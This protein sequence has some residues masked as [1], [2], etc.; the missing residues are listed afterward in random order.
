MLKYSICIT[1]RNEIRTIRQ[2]LDSIL[3]QI[4]DRFEVIVVD[5]YSDDGSLG[6]LSEYSKLGRLKLIVKECNRGTGRQIAFENS[7][8]KYVLANMDLDDTFKP[9]LTRL[10]DTYHAKFEGFLLYVNK[11]PNWGGVT[12][13]P[14]DLISQIGGW[15]DLQ[16][17]EDWDLWARAGKIGRF[18]TVEYEI[19]ESI[20]GH[21][22][23]KVLKKFRQ[24]FIKYR[25]IHR[26]GRQIFTK[27]ERVSATQR[28]IA[29]L[30]RM[31][32]FFYPSYGDPFN[33]IFNPWDKAYVVQWIDVSS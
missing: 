11:P 18:K 7:S 30:A 5:S 27:N 25:E 10:L 1:C 26:L 28:L 21:L 22:E 19:R 2:S 23:K 33:K 32:S 29:Y 17:S 20:G 15:R 3:H 4:D 9:E 12:I 14:R 13:G 6:V 24:R 8:G 31:S 16:Y